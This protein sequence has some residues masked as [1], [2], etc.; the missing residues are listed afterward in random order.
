MNKCFQSRFQNEY[1]VIG[2]IGKGNYAKV[3]S[4]RHKITGQRFAAKCFEKEKIL[5][6][7][8]GKDSLFNEIKVM[9]RLQEC[10]YVIK[11]YETFEG[12]S[13]FYLIMELVEGVSLYEEIN[14]RKIKAFS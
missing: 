10:P 4:V 11:L 14:M 1:D 7:D 5:S 8:K 13:T 3:F 6:A 2:M 9:R 12:D